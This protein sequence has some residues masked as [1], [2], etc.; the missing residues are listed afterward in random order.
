MHITKLKQ[1]HIMYLVQVGPSVGEE[2]YIVP[3]VTPSTTI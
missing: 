3:I 1:I 2:Q